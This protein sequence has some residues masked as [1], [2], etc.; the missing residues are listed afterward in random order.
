MKISVAVSYVVITYYI[1]TLDCFGR[2]ATAG[3]KTRVAPAGTDS[4]LSAFSKFLIIWLTEEI[5][6]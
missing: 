4:I 5:F 3:G 2:G 6:V 1:Y